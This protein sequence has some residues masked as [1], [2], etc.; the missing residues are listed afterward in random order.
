[1][2]LKHFR[3]VLYIEANSW[4]ISANCGSAALYLPK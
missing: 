2:R 4:H 1:M 3:S